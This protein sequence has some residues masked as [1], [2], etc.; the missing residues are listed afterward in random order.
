MMTGYSS[1]TFPPSATFSSADLSHLWA[2]GTY[3]ISAVYKI[4]QQLENKHQNTREKKVISFSSHHNQLFYTGCFFLFCQIVMSHTGGIYTL[5]IF[6]FIERIDF[7]VY[8]LFRQQRVW[9]RQ[10]SRPGVPV[11]PTDMIW[12]LHQCRCRC[13]D[14]ETIG[15]GSKWGHHTFSNWLFSQAFTCPYIHTWDEL[16]LSVS[17]HN[18]PSFTLRICCRLVCPFMWHLQL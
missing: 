6:F 8:I 16:L 11:E 15:N 14:K 12:S 1:W 10:T 7:I 2:P 3:L 17:V 9:G 18:G 4:Y 13:W 5:S